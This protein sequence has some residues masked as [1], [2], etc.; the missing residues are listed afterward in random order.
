[1][2]RPADATETNECWK[3]ALASKTRPTA[4]VLSR[5]DLPVFDRTKLGA[6][7][8]VKKG[9]YVLAD[10]PSGLP[11]RA[12]LIATGSEVSLA[13]AA[14]K[15]LAAAKI[16]ARVVSMPSWELFEEQEESY[17]ASVL[18][19]EVTARV[20]L[21]AGATF[22]WTRW[23]GE[24]GVAL[25]LDR[26]GASAPASTLYDKL[27]FSLERIVRTVKSLVNDTV[28]AGR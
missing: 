12:V 24:R 23:V 25:G 3:L 10:A 4:L 26:Y 13:L 5:Q 28:L 17:R 20:S 21:E 16:G 6:A 7:E 15:E 14:Q 11:L 27:G 22:G 9:A 2:F 1:V 19:P 8:L 18:P